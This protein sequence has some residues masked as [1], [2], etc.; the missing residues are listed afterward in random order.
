MLTVCLKDKHV[1]MWLVKD[2]LTVATNI[3]WCSVT[4]QRGLHCRK[5][6]PPG[7]KLNKHQEKKEILEAVQRQCVFCLFC[8]NLRGAL[9]LQCWK[10]QEFDRAELPKKGMTGY[11]TTKE[12]EVLWADE[13]REE[14]KIQPWSSW[15]VEVTLKIPQWKWN[16][17]Q[18]WTIS[19]RFQ[20]GSFAGPFFCF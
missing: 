7:I 2:E 5:G 8:K 11:R 9:K 18:D 6:S 13:W 12:K 1:E 4:L 19:C 17:F 10:E 16:C 20:K 3:Y 14:S 15:A